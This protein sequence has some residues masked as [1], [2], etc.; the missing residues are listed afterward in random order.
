MGTLLLGGASGMR[1]LTTFHVVE[2]GSLRTCGYLKSETCVCQGHSLE[3]HNEE[4]FYQEFHLR[5]GKMNKSC[6]ECKR[7][8]IWISASNKDKSIVGI[9]SAGLITPLLAS[10]ILLYHSLFLNLLTRQSPSV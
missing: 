7:G 8:S 10:L 3:P 6:Q 4:S 5:N 9:R 1:R 2:R